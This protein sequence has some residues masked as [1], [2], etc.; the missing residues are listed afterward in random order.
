MKVLAA[1]LLALL[2]LSACKAAPGISS[3]DSTTCR[4]ESAAIDTRGAA[5]E[6]ALAASPP[7]SAAR[8]QALYDRS[9]VHYARGNKPSA[10]ADLD[11]SLAIHQAKEPL[12]NRGVLHGELGDAD[13]AL[14]D[15]DAYIRIDPQAAI[16]YTN[17]GIVEERQHRY[18][19]ALKDYT[20]AIEVEPGDYHAYGARCWLVGALMQD[21]K[22]ALA[23][24]DKVVQLE[25]KDWNSHNSRGFVLYRL[26]RFEEAVAAYDSAIGVNP[27]VPSSW[28]MRGMARKALGDPEGEADIAKGKAM[29]PNVA[30]RYGSYG[31]QID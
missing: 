10:L 7:G 5:C 19:T 16:G 17:R 2:C 30:A 18:A 6:R 23:D 3:V 22:S 28:L 14:Q 1:T 13:A 9:F 24:C 12:L 15:F 29:D 11:A 20:R 31:V 26:G 8:A 4:D 21:P 25:P 27:S